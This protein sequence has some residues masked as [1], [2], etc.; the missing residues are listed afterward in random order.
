MYIICAKN[1]QDEPHVTDPLKRTEICT[2]MIYTRMRALQLLEEGKINSRDTIVTRK[3][4]SCLYENIFENVIDWDDFLFQN[5]NL[6]DIIDLVSE[7]NNGIIDSSESYKKAFPSNPNH[8]FNINTF[9]VPNLKDFICIL[10]RGVQNSAEK[11]LSPNYWN[12]LIKEIDKEKFDVYVFGETN[13]ILFSENIIPV[14]NFMYWCSLLASENCKAVVSTCT[15]GVYPLFFM[16]NQ[17]SELIIIDPNSYSEIHKNSPSFYNE[18]INFK[19]VK[20]DKYFY[21]PDPKSFSELIINT[22]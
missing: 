22:L 9:P 1:I 15:G 4:R 16:G 5:W 21:T 3:D 10:V 8:I 20:V 13:D 11:N 17:N 14:N 18:C 2:E 19:K 12:D 7:I 6:I